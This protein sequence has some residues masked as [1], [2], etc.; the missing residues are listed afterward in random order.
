M[1]P[2][3]G[4]ENITTFLGEPRF[5]IRESVC[6]FLFFTDILRLN[7]LMYL[8]YSHTQRLWLFYYRW[9]FGAVIGSKIEAEQ[10]DSTV[11]PSQNEKNPEVD[12][13]KAAI[14]K[15]EEE[16]Q[17]ERAFEKNNREDI[18]C[19]RLESTEKWWASSAIVRECL[20]ALSSFW[21]HGKLVTHRVT[22]G[23]ALKLL[24]QFPS[25]PCFLKSSKQSNLILIC[26]FSHVNLI[27]PLSSTSLF[28]KPFFLAISFL[29][30]WDHTWPQHSKWEYATF[31]CRDI[32]FGDYCWVNS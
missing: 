26:L 32:R 17:L 11:E 10:M 25:S 3:E 23:G 22:R 19:T 31:W 24:L 14:N 16:G 8:L 2:I 29:R 18:F 21:H 30:S 15:L 12:E 7:S 6:F 5:L 20:R 9:G 4:T 28:S 13:I 1:C 27:T